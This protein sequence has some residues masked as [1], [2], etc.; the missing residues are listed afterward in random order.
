M[1]R[2]GIIGILWVALLGLL[3]VLPGCNSMRNTMVY[4]ISLHQ[5]TGEA[6][7]AMGS[8]YT[9]ILYGTDGVTSTMVRAI[10]LVSSINIT[11]AEILPTRDDRHCGI[12]IFFDQ[13]GSQRWAQAT[14][15]RGG[16]LLAIVVDGMMA[17][18]MQ[19]PGH[20]SEQGYADLP[21]VWHRLEAE[22]IV[23]H[24]EKNYKKA[25]RHW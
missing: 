21:P 8:S 24:A 20:M 18:T 7:N 15:Y 4:R 17:G 13:E 5:L 2:T 11:S 1:K 14:G 6:E 10:P 22:D 3:A 9:M 16:D 19:L 23:K 25:P 12:R